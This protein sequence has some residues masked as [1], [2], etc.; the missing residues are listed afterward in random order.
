M[1]RGNTPFQKAKWLTGKGSNFLSLFRAPTPCDPQLAHFHLSGRKNLGFKS[2]PVN[3]GNMNQNIAG[4]WGHVQALHCSKPQL[5]AA[6]SI[7]SLSVP[8]LTTLR[9]CLERWAP[10]VTG[11]TPAKQS[12]SIVCQH[13]SVC[14]PG[15]SPPGRT[16]NCFLSITDAERQGD[17]AKTRKKTNF[18]PVILTLWCVF[19]VEMSRCKL[20]AYGFDT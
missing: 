14:Q 9:S 5:P 2:S 11:N 20:C 19:R 16:A 8:A 7:S 15:D 10:R 6:P 17:S 3:S 4:S 13:Q 12:V 18:P 1:N